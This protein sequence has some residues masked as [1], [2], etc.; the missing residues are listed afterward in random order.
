ML[1]GRDEREHHDRLRHSPSRIRSVLGIETVVAPFKLLFVFLDERLAQS[2][3]IEKASAEGEEAH[4]EH[5]AF[6]GHNVLLY[7]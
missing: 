5:C 2:A 3:A 4:K 6:V 1:L 7:G